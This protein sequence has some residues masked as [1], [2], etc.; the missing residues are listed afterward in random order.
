M[1]GGWRELPLP[2]RPA[3]PCS[4]VHTH[5]LDLFA[6]PQAAPC[7]CRLPRLQPASLCPLPALSGEELE[8]ERGLSTDQ[9]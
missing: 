5:I 3:P 4:P 1:L 9:R 7:L 2:R 6:C 8:R